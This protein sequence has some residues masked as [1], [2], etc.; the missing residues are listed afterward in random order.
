MRSSESANSPSQAISVRIRWRSRSRNTLASA[1]SQNRYS[2]G[3][4]R[5]RLASRRAT[6]ATTGDG[7]GWP[8]RYRPAAGAARAEGEG[9][10]EHAVDVDAEPARHPR[11]VDRGAQPAA[12]TGAG[13]NELQ[14]DGQKPAGDDDQEP[15]A[16]DADPEQFEAALQGA[17]D[18]DED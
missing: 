3:C 5:A 8:R 13:E 16:P 4:Q 10:R 18:L 12:E 14:G 11:I 1:A 17:R 6:S 9:Q 2:S 7:I 15:I